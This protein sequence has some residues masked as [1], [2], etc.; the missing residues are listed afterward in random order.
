MAKYVTVMLGVVAMSGG[1]WMLAA[2]WPLLWIAVQVAVPVLLVLGGLLAIGVGLG[3][4]RDAAADRAAQS[5]RSAEPPAP[6]R[7]F[8]P[9]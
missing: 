7:R 3:E 4:I 8:P 6:P 1:V 2:T 5:P 9:Q